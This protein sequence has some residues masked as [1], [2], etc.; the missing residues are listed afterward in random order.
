MSVNI[1]LVPH[2]ATDEA[3]IAMI[4]PVS[5]TLAQRASK[6]YPPGNV[7]I[8]GVAFP[9]STTGDAVITWAHRYRLGPF[10][11]AQD[12]GN[13]SGGPEGTYT[14]EIRVNNVLV[15]TV[16]GLTGTTYT[17][18]YAQRVIDDANPA[19]LTS[20]KIFPVNNSLSGTA[21]TLTFLMNP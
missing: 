15:H 4:T 18:T 13:V 5:V 9:T 2:S 11:V 7:K 1:K 19:H 20:I 14:I 10:I 16:T 17:Y 21:R 8:N 6:P 3:D 12:A